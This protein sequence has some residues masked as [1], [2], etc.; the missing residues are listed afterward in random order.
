[1][2]NRKGPDEDSLTGVLGVCFDKQSGKCRAQRT[3]YKQKVL[4]KLFN[5]I[6]E[7]KEAYLSFEEN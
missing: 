7:A 2:Q 1:M 6:E 5:T 4:N 3:I